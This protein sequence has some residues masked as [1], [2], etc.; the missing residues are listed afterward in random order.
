[1]AS[2]FPT[3][4]KLHVGDNLLEVTW[5]DEHVSRYAGSYLRKICPCAACVGHAPGERE[6]P[7]WQQVEGVR[8]T[9]VEAVGTYALKLDLS[10]AHASGIYT[11]DFLRRSCPSERPDVDEVGHPTIH[12]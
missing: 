10:D 4:I 3:A 7:S 12:P 5:S 11:Y 1:M 9:H 6:P 8:V 2:A